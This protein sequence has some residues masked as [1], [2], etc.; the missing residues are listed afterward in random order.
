MTFLRIA[1]VAALAL[2]TLSACSNDGEVPRLM[3]LQSHQ[4]SPD[5]FSIVPTQPLQAPP[6]YQ[7]LPTPTPGGGNLVDPDPRAAAVEALGGRISAER[8]SGVPAA[9]AG[10]VQYAGRNGLSPDIRATLAAEDEEVRRDGQ[11]RILERM[12]NSNMYRAAY[13]DQILDPQAELLRWRAAGV[14]TPAAPPPPE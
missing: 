11:G 13:E 1:S 7:S 2:A 12:F 4:D 10:L 6:D 5:E 8:T 9:D 3:N 14:R